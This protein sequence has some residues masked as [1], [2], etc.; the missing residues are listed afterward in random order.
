VVKSGSTSL[1]VLD[2]VAQII[3]SVWHHLHP[4]KSA[5][6][7]FFFCV[8]VFPF[9]LHT[10]SLSLNYVLCVVLV[11]V[12]QPPKLTGVGIWLLSLLLVY[13]PTAFLKETNK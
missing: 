12:L 9:G 11:S 13:L 8:W 3:S 2:D 4:S 1:P 10:P 6:S 7:G 5:S